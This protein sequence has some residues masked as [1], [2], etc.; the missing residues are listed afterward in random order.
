MAVT[1]TEQNEVF[2][3]LVTTTMRDYHPLLV[4]QI[5]AEVALLSHF[6]ATGKIKMLPGGNEIAVG[7]VGAKN[8]NFEWYQG[9][10]PAT[11]NESEQMTRAIYRWA[12]SR[13]AVKISDQDVDINS[14]DK[15]RLHNLLME[16]VQNAKRSITDEINVALNGASTVNG[17]LH[18]IGTFITETANVAKGGIDPT[19][20]GMD[21][22]DNHRIT[23]SVERYDLK[24]T[25]L[26]T[27]FNQCIAK[28][29]APQRDG[30]VM[31]SDV[32]VFEGYEESIEDI[33][34]VML[35]EARKEKLGFGLMDVLG[36]RGKPYFWDDSAE[37]DTLRLL[38]TN[39]LQL[40]VHSKRNFAPDPARTYPDAHATVSYIR[41]MGQLTCNFL[42]AQGGLFNI[43]STQS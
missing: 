30:I 15:T 18:G 42:G 10:T 27:L 8:P 13:N 19:D 9:S 24:N 32:G 40:V 31:V 4:P 26:R 37:A 34:R 28:V 39:F 2:N 5:Y 29:P 41:F 11:A 35:T 3:N 7:I 33:A 1:P 12:L 16:L 17:E 43:G 6:K 14:G 22:W 20:P 21:F 36:Y 38:N 25:G 23:A